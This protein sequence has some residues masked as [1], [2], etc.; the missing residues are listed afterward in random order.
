MPLRALFLALL[1]SGCGAHQGGSAADQSAASADPY[2]AA[3]ERNSAG[4]EYDEA[5]HYRLGDYRVYFPKSDGVIHPPGGAPSGLVVA[6]SGVLSETGG[7]WRGLLL[8]GEPMAIAEF[9]VNAARNPVLVR[10]PKDLGSRVTGGAPELYQRY[11][12]APAREALP[13]GTLRFTYWFAYPPS[14]EPHR[15][16][17]RVEAGGGVA[18]AREVVHQLATPA[19]L[20]DQRIAQLS[21]DDTWTRIAAAKALASAPDPRGLSR[22]RA[23]LAAAFDGE[24]QAAIAALAALRDAAAVADLVQALARETDPQNLVA[25]VDALALFRPATDQAILACARTHPNE[26]V[27][28]RCTWVVTH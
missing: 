24:R 17:I 2:L 11:V 28:S 4:G 25:L 10:G 9:L 1:A 19:E 7:D 23:M 13:D 16:L 6:P 26:S 21:N 27:R 14:F 15:M 3:I 5:P 8:A 20:A 12:A 22:L 18:F